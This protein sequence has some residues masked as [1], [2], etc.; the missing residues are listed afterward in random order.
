MGFNFGNNTKTGFQKSI[1]AKQAFFNRLKR[2]FKVSKD[3]SERRFLKSEASHVC[4][5]LKQCCKQWKACGFGACTWVTKGFTVTNF[6]CSKPASRKTST[7]TTTRKSCSRTTARSSTKRTP[8]RR[9]KAR[10][11]SRKRTTV[12]RKSYVAW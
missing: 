1:K 8:S 12:S 4:T 10:T 5:E 3:L 9:P 6:T 7:R 11:A 2:R